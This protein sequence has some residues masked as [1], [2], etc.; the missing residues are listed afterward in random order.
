MEIQESQNYHLKNKKAE[1]LLIEKLKS[2]GFTDI[3]SDKDGRRKCIIIN[4]NHR[5]IKIYFNSRYKGDWQPSIKFSDNCNPN[6]KNNK[7]WIFIDVPD[8][9]FYVVP[10]RWMAR[11][12][13]DSHQKYIE[14][15]GGKRKINNDSLHHK[16]THDQIK[17][18]KDSWDLLD[19]KYET[20]QYNH[21]DIEISEFPEGK[22]IE[23]IHK[24][25]ERNYT[26]I[27]KAKEKYY[28]E[29]GKLNCMICGFNFEDMYG[30]IGKGFIE[31]HHILPVS[32][33]TE[34]SI[35][36]LEEIVLV[37]SNCHKM[38]HR[39]RPWLKKEELSKL[40][41]KNS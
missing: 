33:L 38:I 24:I 9:E 40:L 26:L 2:I 34:N 12:I 13:Y 19:K 18:W 30:E 14:K 5:K 22:E 11:Q 31:A 15:Y 36:R 10:E 32:E 21:I 41:E 7:F 37:C 1:Q 29:Y 6:E 17:Q 25:R 4:Q 28:Q 16:T 3:K 27:K 8:N 23:R 20:K 39:R 35:T